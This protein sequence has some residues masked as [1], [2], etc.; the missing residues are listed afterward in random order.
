MLTPEGQK[1]M[2]EQN[3]HDKICSKLVAFGAE[4][5]SKLMKK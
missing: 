2:K 1:R 3:I 5:A 4:E